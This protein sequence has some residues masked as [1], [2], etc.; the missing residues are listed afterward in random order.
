VGVFFDEVDGAIWVRG[1]DYKASFS[2]DAMSFI[3]FLGSDAPRNFPV[4]FRVDGVEAG[5]E[6][7]PVGRGHAVRQDKQ[8]TI[9]HGS[10][11]E[12]YEVAPG[13]VEQRF[14]FDRSPGMGD[15]VVRL[16]LTTELEAVEQ[17]RWRDP[18]F[19]RSRRRA[20]RSR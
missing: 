17:A 8:I 7:L 13:Q 5:G 14:R 15:A 2:A 1:N 10:I 6:S 11:A 3:P 4:T 18:L 12:I 20:V 9:D 19:E 16:K